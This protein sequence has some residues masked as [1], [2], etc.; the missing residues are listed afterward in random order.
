MITVAVIGVVAMTA[1]VWFFASSME[2]ERA[3]EKRRVKM[4]LLTP[5]GR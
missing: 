3:T 4:L 5:S 1:L 2:R